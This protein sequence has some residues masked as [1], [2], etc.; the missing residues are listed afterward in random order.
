MPHIFVSVN[1]VYEPTTFSTRVDVETGV[2]TEIIAQAMGGQHYIVSNQPISELLLV[3]CSQVV[4]GHI[5]LGIHKLF[6][7]GVV[8]PFRMRVYLRLCESGHQWV[9]PRS[10]TRHWNGP[11]NSAPSSERG[12]SEKSVMR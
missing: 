6:L 1:C 4:K 12:D 3:K 11:W 10:S 2:V 9:M 8:E 7:E 5:L